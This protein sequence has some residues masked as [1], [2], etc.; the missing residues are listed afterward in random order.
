LRWDEARD[1]PEKDTPVI[2]VGPGEGVRRLAAAGGLSLPDGLGHGAAEGYRIGM[3]SRRGAPVVWVA[4]ND[5][6]GTLF[7]VG[8]LLRTLRM[9][10]DRVWMPGDFRAESAPRTALRGHQ[11]GY[12][13]KTNSYD[14]WTVAMWEQYIRD[15]AVFG[16]NAIELIPPRSDDAADSPL[17]PLPPLRMMTEVSRLADDYGLD[18][19][20]WYPALDRDYADPATVDFALKEWAAVFRALPRLDAVFVP[21]GDPGATRPKVFLP[22]LE[23][24]AANLRHF[25]PKAQMWVSPQ[26]FAKPE[27]DEFLRLLRAEPAWLTGV[28]YGPQVRLPLA[29]LRRALPRRY[30]IRNYPDITHSRHC[31]YPVP[32]WDVAFALTEGREVSNPRPLQTAN[33]FR[34]TR[35]YTVGFITYSEGCHDDVNKCVWSALGWDERA[36]VREVLREYSR[37]FIGPAFEERFA[38]GLLA[39]EKD[40]EGPVLDNAGID[41]TLAAFRAMEKAAP[42]PVRLNWRFQQALYRAYYD[43]YVRARLKYEHGLEEAARAKLGEARALGSLRAMAEAEA[44]LDRATKEPVARDLRA[45]VFELAEALFQSIRAQLSVPRYY[46]I[47]VE[48][49]ANL[50]RIDCP[51]NDAGW[52]RARCAAIRRL[53]D[54]AARVA[55]IEAALKRTDPGP[56]GFYD[57]LGDPAR[58]PHLVRGLGPAKDPEFRA[59]SLVGFGF[60]GPGPDQSLPRAWW[61]HAESLFD[62]PLRVRYTGLDPAAAYRVR[63][64]YGQEEERTKVRL[65]A[66]DRFEV[67]GYLGRSFEPLEFAIPAGATA[68]GELTLTW[69][70]EPGGGGA[71]RGCQVAEV[72]LLKKGG[73]H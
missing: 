13:P 18:V 50:D 38:D 69:T 55:A 32:D 4:G 41:A 60:R 8:R 53:P 24:Q 43:G 40:W 62:A 42:P 29:E 73:R 49:G 6:R 17:F 34:V 68:G 54:E 35:P 67:H 33:I 59:S 48:R 65:V 72:S 16:C 47:A 37:Y 52:L 66:N 71:G 56:G 61:Q 44:I 20:V 22:L 58:Q 28:V 45:R 2:L 23:K 25:H 3:A 26:G 36:D 30:P 64:V 51:L 31:Q 9:E 57:D 10:R 15:L 12:R 19:W 27:M 1:W 21:G 14:G 39:L 11:L 63:V 46:A 70:A 7:G 5:A